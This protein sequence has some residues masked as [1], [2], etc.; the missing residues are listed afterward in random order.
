MATT[1]ISET[2]IHRVAEKLPTAPRLLVELGRLM[3]NP[4]VDSEEI[5]ALL[6]QDPPLVAQVI[7]MANSVAY[8]PPEPVGS[9]ERAL[10]SVGFA[11]VHR[12]VG[13]VAAS[14]LSDQE[15]ALYPID[16]PN[17]RLNALFVAV[18][19]EELAKWANERPLTCYT[20]GLLRTIGIMA[21]EH[22]VSPGE[23]IPTFE[24]SGEIELDVW[25]QKY[26]G[27]TNVEVAQK[28]L[29]HWRLPHETATAIRFH[30][31]PEGRHNPQ[32]HLLKLAATAAADRY[33]GIH[34]EEA[35][36]RITP[37]NFA[38][39]GISLDTFRSACVKA[40]RSFDRLKVAVA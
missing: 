18:L 32:I 17:L 15:T 40:Q 4:R 25:E 14:Q 13:V 29:L 37:E 22:L 24:E 39:A 1:Q 16:G 12:L 20:V 7:R 31:R 38:K 28:I 30:Y 23:G 11:E 33:H 8:S 34:G 3:H 26:L 6:R 9:L 2:E 36:W 27:I 5:V 10:A 35:Y 21:I 19:M